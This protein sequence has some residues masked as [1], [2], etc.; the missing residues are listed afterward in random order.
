[1]TRRNNAIKMLLKKR[2][3]EQK[4]NEKAN[5]VPRKE[6]SAQKR[7]G[8]PILQMDDEMNTIEQFDTIAE[9]SRKTN[10]NSKSIRDA[11]K[12]VQKHAGGFIWRYIDEYKTE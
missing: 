12:R 10:I 1:M 11:A 5:S 2:E 3:K 7:K 6:K 9:A 8:R 4:N